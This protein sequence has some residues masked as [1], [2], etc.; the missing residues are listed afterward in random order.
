MLRHA[1][2]ACLALLPLIPTGAVA[3]EVTEF[4]LDNGLHAVVIEDHRAPVVVHML[5]YRVG[6]A[7]EPPGRSGI[8][9]F[10]EHLMFKA[11]ETLESGEFSDTVEANGGSDN[12]F[13]SWDYT[14][15]Y[16]RVASDRLGLM[17]Q[18]EADRMRNLLLTDDD[19][20]TERSVILEERAQRTD[21][22]A[23]ALFNEQLRAS[24]YLAHPYRIPIGGWRHEIEALDREDVFSFYHDYYSPDNAILIVAGDVTPEEVRALAEEHYGPLE[25]SGIEP[26][27]RP[28]DPP[29]I[30]DRR[31][32]YEDPRV[33]DPYVVR[34]YIAPERDAGDQR[35]A[36]ALTLLSNVLAG[37]GATAVLPRVLQVEEARSLYASA[38]YSGTNLDDTTFSI[39]NVPVPGVSLE[40][41]EADLD[42]V[43]AQFLEDG[44]DPEQFARI[45]FQWE[46]EMIYAQDDVGDLARMYGVG[47]TSG[48]TVQDIQDWPDV[49]ASITPEEVME[50]ARMIFT[51]TTSVT[52]YL[53]APGL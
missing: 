14:G 31:I 12:A 1:M 49:I 38:S 19:I 21:S 40:E 10:L 53:T 27:Q 34:S 6:A 18:M 20:A 36:A 42:R 44:I 15:Y 24:L 17:M 23:G 5:W 39:F 11:T 46:A 9:H 52:G 28:S 25:P 35:T 2:A 48:L 45:Q 30:A 32:Y 37:S 16:Q 3:N 7:D 50:A 22:S 47:L 4:T 8:A 26:R 51:E 43:I 41:A 33:S 29:Q 13:T